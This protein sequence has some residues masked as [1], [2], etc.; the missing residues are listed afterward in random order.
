MRNHGTPN[1]ASLGHKVAAED[2]ARVVVMMEFRAEHAM[3]A[4]DSDV[5]FCG[6]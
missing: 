4:G 6:E 1:D 5:A 2:A 3:R